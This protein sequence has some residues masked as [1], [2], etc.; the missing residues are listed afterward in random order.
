MKITKG[1]KISNR[2]DFGPVFFV[3]PNP[4]RAVGLEKGIKNYHIICSH[5]LDIIEYLREDGVPVLCLNDDMIKNTGKLLENEKVLNYIKAQS[6]GEVPNVV[7]FK[8]SPKIEKICELNKFNHAGNDWRLNRKFENKINFVDISGKL[9]IPNAG[10]RVVKLGDFEVVKDYFEGGAKCVI[11]LPRGFSGNSTFLLGSREDFDRLAEKL[12]GRSVKI[13]KYL[14]G[15]TFTINGCVAKG[16]VFV[17]KPIYQITGFTDFNGN[18]MGTSGNDYA[19][20][21]TL[22]PEA[23]KKIFD[24]TKKIG[25]YMSREGYRGIFGLDFIVPENGEVNLIEINPRLVGSIP[26]Y[27]K[28]QIESGEFPFLAM[29][30]GEFIY[31]KNSAGSRPEQ[32]YT[33]W[34]KEDN[35]SASQLILRNTGKRPLILDKAVSSGIY[36]LEKRKLV[37]SGKGYFIGAR[38]GRDEILIQCASQGSLINPDMEYANIQTSYGIMKE[39]GFDEGFSDIIGLVQDRIKLKE[40]A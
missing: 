5:Y 15:E 24:Y 11:Q 29:H 16:D 37:F 19:Y 27:T 13:A 18:N 31:G 28:L 26:V 20:S 9:N 32:S 8:P 7:T 34:R 40:T 2:L 17:G 23:R 38:L 4:N 30:L 21:V 3:T 14:A 22:G 35:F 6:K 1:K 36:K 12:G 33:V 39:K 25:K 10:S